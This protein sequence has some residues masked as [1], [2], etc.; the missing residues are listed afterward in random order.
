MRQILAARESGDARSQLAFD[1][2][3]HSLVRHAGMMIAVLGGIDA[4]VFTGGVGENSALVREA[5]CESLAY[6]G[7]MLDR[8]KNERIKGDMAIHESS[9][10]VPVLVIHAREEWEIARACSTLV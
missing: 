3:V 9:S 1:V 5:L 2:Y 8:E 4:L 7:L 10:Q 6:L